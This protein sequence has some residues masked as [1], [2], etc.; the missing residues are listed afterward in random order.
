MNLSVVFSF[1][2]QCFLV[3]SAM[4]DGLVRIS[5]RRMLNPDLYLIVGTTHNM[6]WIGA[7]ACVAFV[8]L[9]L[10]RFSI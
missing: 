10:D 4:Q 8:V 5:S 6:P 7:F 2:G 9:S 3:F 1:L